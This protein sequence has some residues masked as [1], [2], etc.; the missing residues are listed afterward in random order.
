MNEYSGMSGITRDTSTIGTE[1]AVPGNLVPLSDG[2]HRLW[3][4]G[5]FCLFPPKNESHEWRLHCI[6]LKPREKVARKHHRRPLRGGLTYVSPACAYCRYVYSIC[7]K[8]EE[9]F[10]AKSARRRLGGSVIPTQWVDAA[11][12]LRRRQERIRNTSP[13]KKS[14]S[15][16]PRKRVRS[17]SQNDEACER[18]YETSSGTDSAVELDRA[19]SIPRGRSRSRKQDRKRAAMLRSSNPPQYKRRRID[20][21]SGSYA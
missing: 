10:L 7:G 2:L 19:E 21:P 12:R 3:D 4:S 16:S 15:G 17:H 5:F 13:T 11:E 20:C 9:T 18:L 8:Y 6:F 14:R 1:M